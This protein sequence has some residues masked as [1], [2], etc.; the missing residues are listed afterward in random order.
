MMKYVFIVLIL[1]CAL[2]GEMTKPSGR[3]RESGW[4]IQTRPRSYSALLLE[5]RMEAAAAA[6]TLD[7]EIGLK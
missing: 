4:V 3:C 7:K 1:L 5:I 6:V 2:S